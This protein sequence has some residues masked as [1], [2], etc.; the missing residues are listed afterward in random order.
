M[1]RLL[2]LSALIICSLAAWSQEVDLTQLDWYVR[3][4][5]NRGW[6]TSAPSPDDA[7]WQRVTAPAGERTLLIRDLP[8]PGMV[9]GNP[10]NFLNDRVATVTVLIPFEADFSLFSL[11]DVALY[12]AHIG[13]IYEIYINGQPSNPEEEGNLLNRLSVLYDANIVNRNQLRHGVLIPFG[14]N[15]IQP[16]INIIAIRL[17]GPANDD[18]FGLA[19]RSPYLLGSY[20]LLSALRNE[21][22]EISLIGIYIIFAL[23]TLVLF[24]LRPRDL[25][26]LFF[27]LTTIAFSVF[28]A[29]RT[30]L[31][32]SLVSNIYILARLELASMF[33]IMPFFFAFLDHLERHRLTLVTKLYSLL[34][35]GMIAAT[36]FLRLE[37][38]HNIWRYSTP[39]LLVYALVFVIGKVVVH[40]VR[41]LRSSNTRKGFGGLV[42]VLY[43]FFASTDSGKIV[44]GALVIM[45]A[46]VLDILR[47]MRGQDL[48][49]TGYAFVFFLLGA[50]SMLAGRFINV[51]NSLETL[52]AGLELKVEERTAE[53]TQ[54]AEAQLQINARIAESNHGLRTAMEE[55][56]RDMKVAISVQKGFFPGVAPKLAGWDIALA[57]EVASGISGDFYDFYQKAGKLEGVILG[58]VSGQGIASGLIT[59]LTRSIFFRKFNEFTGRPMPAMMYQINKEMVRELASV[60]N[61]ISGVMLRIRDKHFEYANAAGADA[62]IKR[63]A[64][65][66]FTPLIP[67]D[68]PDFRM[69]PLGRNQLEEDA[70][71][72]ALPLS[73]GDTILL[74]TEYL[75]T[76]KNSKGEAYGSARLA[77]SLKRADQDSAQT[78]LSSI[79][80]DYRNFLVGA[81]R[82]DDTTVLVLRKS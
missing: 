27:A 43:R 14:R 64:D 34:T 51:Y 22:L 2:C 80:I 13:H 17:S 73:S 4:G 6:T 56:E 46:L 54:A 37:P 48:I 61:S 63:K 29:T 25:E 35:L 24:I 70:K 16:G 7:N 15:V 60:D 67:G 21:S 82:Q 32:I 33:M 18:Q 20:R 71:C 65:Q 38:F 26:Y 79:M 23:Y 68:Q 69:V 74:F 47:L 1:K 42:A 57:F 39:V 77:A 10:W 31:V 66:T 81:K 19:L 52:N 59:V 41:E 11:N 58:S 50:A 76:A 45:V 62:L 40:D 8:I 49:Y 53:L 5:F 36:L 55:A 72:L 78:L 28:L 30:H 3:G 9:E 75:L 12:L 44:V